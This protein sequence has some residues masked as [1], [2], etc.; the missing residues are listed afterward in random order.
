MPAK[1]AGEERQVIASG[2]GIPHNPEQY[3]R[4]LAKL[5]IEPDNYSQKGVVE[6]LEK[7]LAE[8]LGKE[9]AIWMPTGT[10]A[11]HMAVRILA[12]DRKR[13]LVQH[14]SHLYNDTGDCAETLSGLNLIPLPACTLDAVEQAWSRASSSRVSV[15]IGAMQI[16][17]P[18]R[19]ANGEMVDFGEM[20]KICA[21]LRDRKVGTHLDGARLFLG[22]AY[23][24]VSIKDYAA[25]FDTVYISMYK[26]FN[27]AAGAI[28]AGPKAQLENLFHAR[29]MFG[30]GLYHSWP[31]A[32]VALHYANGF[33]AR[34]KKAVETSETMIAAMQKDNN[35]ELQRIPSGTN[36]FRFRVRGVNTTIYQQ[37]LEDAGVTA[38]TPESGDWYAL[39]VNETWLRQTP[40]E[41]LA[42]FRKALG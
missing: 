22:A 11:N 27:A 32:A 28:L 20:K 36:I 17:T 5:S 31:F 35:F 15:P 3:T 13:V 34:F 41:I 9:H 33:E 42:A 30:G 2:D 19:R 6:T 25:L 38:R 14:D 4:L 21:F 1:A 23:T 40:D 26:Y 16:E 24:G 18:V 8:M 37:R 29:R 10:L 39:Q 7:R 12:G